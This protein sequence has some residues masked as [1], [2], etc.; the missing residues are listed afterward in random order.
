VQ[1]V[2][3]PTG[4]LQLLLIEKPLGGIDGL[5]QKSL[6]HIR[7]IAQSLSPSHHPSPSLHGPQA[8]QYVT[9]GGVNR[10]PS[11]GSRF[12]FIQVLLLHKRSLAH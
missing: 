2:A 10:Q 5:T 9:S 12:I 8:P 1:Y 6:L 11:E 7:P 4:T 3:E